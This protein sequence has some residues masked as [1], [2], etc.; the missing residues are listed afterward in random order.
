MAGIVVRIMGRIMAES[1]QNNGRIMAE[2]WQNHGQ[3]CR[4]KVRAGIVGGIA[5]V[6][7]L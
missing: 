5:D 1:W 7:L 6:F 2:S 3:H 4:Q